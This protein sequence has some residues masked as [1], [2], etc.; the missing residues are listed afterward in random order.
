MTAITYGLLAL[1]KSKKIKER[2][3]YEML[4]CEDS[5]KWPVVEKITIKQ[6]QT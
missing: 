6:T 2:I 3:T 4:L 5:R 1:F